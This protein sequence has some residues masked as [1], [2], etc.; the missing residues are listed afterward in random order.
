MPDECIPPGCKRVVIAAPNG[1]LMD[2]S[3]RPVEACV[4]LTEDMG[5]CY[6]ILVQL[7]EGDLERLAETPAI[8]LSMYTPQIP[9]FA[10]E[11]ADGRGDAGG[12]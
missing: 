2:D 12:G 9:V 5:L 1:D 8:W 7:D 3:V 10:I 11:V 4:G 6:T